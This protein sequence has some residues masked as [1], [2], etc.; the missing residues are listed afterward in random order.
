[1][2]NIELG[3]LQYTTLFCCKYQVPPVLGDLDLYIDI[4][5]M[6]EK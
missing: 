3:E 4:K 1:M 2:I 6:M 5:P